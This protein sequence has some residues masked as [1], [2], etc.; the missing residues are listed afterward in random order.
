MIDVRIPCSVAAVA[1]V[2]SGIVQGQGEVGAIIEAGAWSQF[3]GPGGTGV[4]PASA[5]PPLA[6]DAGSLA[7][8]SP[9]PPG[10][11]SP[12]LAGD[13]LVLTGVE[14]GR[15]VTIALERATGALAWRREAPAV[16]LEPVHDIGSPAASTPLVADG[17][18]VVYFGSFGLLCY[19][20]GGQELWN[21]PLPPP[22]SLYGTATSP[23][24]FKDRVIVV[25]DDETKLEGSA[26]SRSRMLAVTLNSG[27][28]VWEAPRP[29][30]RSGWSTPAVWSH[31]GRS[32][33][34]V[35]GTGRVTAYDPDTGQELWHATGFS[36]ET[37]AQPVAADGLII[38][39]SSQIGGGAD[40]TID[41]QPLWKSVMSFDANGDGRL[42]RAEMTGP[43]TFPLRPELD[44]GHPGYGI[45]LPSNPE[46]RQKRL[47][48]LFAS[49]DADKDGHWSRD[50]FAAAVVNRPGKPR[51][52]AVKPGGAG[53][54]TAS[55]V[56]WE[57]NR[58]IP[59]IPT[60]L[61][62]GPHLYLVRNGGLLS[63]VDAATGSV[64][65]T[66]RL[67]A[68][69]QYSASPVAANGHLFLLSN[70]G[71]LSVVAAGPS[72]TRTHQHDLGASTFVTPAID[73]DSLYIRTSNHLVAFRTAR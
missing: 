47:D 69:G 51:L 49:I 59:E 22:K 3:R 7:W 42:Q 15:L 73:R 13:R 19:D 64:Q 38:V 21:R 18:I 40:E 44:P 52:L 46:A 54:V 16:P 30:V 28:T 37:I 41:P 34:V 39:S 32:E 26:L 25:L 71:L 45:P 12:V 53:D 6:P 14:N 50:E 72:F 20:A 4:A 62:F 23:V 11:S 5:R 48:G 60:P 57:L 66:E 61:V 10:L 27:E 8:K 9:V 36:Q 33:L 70:R 55:H 67:D 65:Y 29:L 63:C 24:L 1:C 2:L 56:A 58:H 35:L 17:R 68:P 31:D 43:F